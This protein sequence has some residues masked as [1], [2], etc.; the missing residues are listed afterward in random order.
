MYCLAYANSVFVYKQP[1]SFYW[2][3]LSGECQVVT[4]LVCIGKS[5]LCP[6]FCCAVLATTT[7][8]Q[9]HRCFPHRE[10]KVS[11]CFVSFWA[12]EQ[13]YL[14]GNVLNEGEIN[15][16]MCQ[17]LFFWVMYLC[18]SYVF[19]YPFGQSLWTFVLMDKQKVW[20]LQCRANR[21]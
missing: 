20:L 6:L 4:W 5:L 2:L 16:I 15:N 17:P 21:F 12:C 1:S 18:V 9:R 7:D 3:H 11:S 14:G 8:W 19:K 13:I 10:C